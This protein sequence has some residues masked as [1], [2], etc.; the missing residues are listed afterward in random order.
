MRVFFFPVFYDELIL[1]TSDFRLVLAGG[2]WWQEVGPKR[3]TSSVY[4]LTWFFP[5]GMLQVGTTAASRAADVTEML[6]FSHLLLLLL[7]AGLEALPGM[8]RKTVFPFSFLI[9]CTP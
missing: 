8:E 1:F 9:S 6:I 4:L 2:K 3:K 7:P 5:V